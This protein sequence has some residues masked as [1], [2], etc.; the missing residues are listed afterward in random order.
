VHGFERFTVPSETYCF[1]IKISQRIEG[2]TTGTIAELLK[3]GSERK[4]HL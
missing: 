2:I 4:A 1:S 3:D